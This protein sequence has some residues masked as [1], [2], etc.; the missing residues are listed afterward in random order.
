M[1]EC[2]SSIYRLLLVVYKLTIIANDFPG[3]VHRVINL[4]EVL[5]LGSD[6]IVILRKYSLEYREV[7]LSHFVDDFV[8][9]VH[10]VVG[11]WVLCDI[12]HG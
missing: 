8:E 5:Y 10:E 3:S 7:V 6:A 2:S 12:E 11:L 4:Q 9:N 1:I